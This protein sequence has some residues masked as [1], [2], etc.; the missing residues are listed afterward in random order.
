MVPWRSLVMASILVAAPAAAQDVLDPNWMAREAELRAQQELAR[1]RSIA[2]QNEITTLEM[3]L[4]AEQSM[5]ALERQ[6]LRP[7]V[8]LPP[9][10][11][12]GAATPARRGVAEI[13]DDRL[14]AS[15]ERVRAAS[16]PAR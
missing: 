14:A 8:Q 9:E 4:Q 3:R 1:Q 5:R 2:L 13:P 15:N 11:R 10:R 12:V 7:Q 6:G 16:R